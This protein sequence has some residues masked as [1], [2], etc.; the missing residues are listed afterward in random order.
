MPEDDLGAGDG[1][2]DIPALRLPQRHT[3]E[4]E[5]LGVVRVN[6]HREPVAD[7]EEL[8][9]QGKD[10]PRV[11]AE[12]CPVVFP[13]GEQGPAVVGTPDDRRAV[14]PRTD[15]PTLPHMAFGHVVPEYR[16]H[17]AAGPDPFPEHWAEAQR[18]GRLSASA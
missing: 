15:T 10:L 14:G 12:E 9:Q 1:D 3:L 8:H 17:L 6:L 5:R 11:V 7:V 16:R 13:H 2:D 18:G 4:P